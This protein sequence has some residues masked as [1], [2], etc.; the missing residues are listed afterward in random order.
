M[1]A[2]SFS[3]L[4]TIAICFS[5]L[6]A[7]GCKSVATQQFYTGN[8][9]LAYAE[10]LTDFSPL[11]YEAKN[12]RVLVNLYEPLVRFDKN[13]RLTSALALS[14]GRLTDTEW[15]F[16][17]RRGVHFHDASDFT[18]KDALYSLNLARES[19]S[20]LAALLENIVSVEALDEFTRSEERRVGK[21][22]RL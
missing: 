8:L 15:E 1:G 7:V 6:F 12:R 2:M 9:T 5:L 3:R 10:N 11:T 21:E 19:H 17:L 22:C 4:I 18:A 13:F 14:W 20:D 16:H